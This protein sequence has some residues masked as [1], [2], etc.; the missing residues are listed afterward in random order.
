LEYAARM[1]LQKEA[2]QFAA[3]PTNLEY[4]QR[5]RR[6]IEFVTSL[7][8]LAVLWEVQNICYSPL[9]KAIGELSPEAESGSA[10]AKTTLDELRQLRDKLHISAG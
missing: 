8:F 5:L 2:T 10:A 6:L 3:Q 9:I 7:P 1:R 4:V